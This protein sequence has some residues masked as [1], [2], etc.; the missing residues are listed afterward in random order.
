MKGRYKKTQSRNKRIFK[1]NHQVEDAL[2]CNS[3]FRPND[4][5]AKKTA[6]EKV[7][8]VYNTIVSKKLNFN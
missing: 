1:I 6:I 4:K 7:S 8:N 2:Q 3:C 5:N